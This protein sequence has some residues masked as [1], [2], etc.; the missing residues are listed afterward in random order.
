MM[1]ALNGLQQPSMQ[2]LPP[3]L[4]ETHECQRPPLLPS[5]VAVSA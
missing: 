1:S 3:R 4:V 5:S 2:S